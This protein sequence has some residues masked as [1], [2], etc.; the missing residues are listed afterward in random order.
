M[1]R[2]ARSVAVPP[3]RWLETPLPARA[4]LPGPPPP[5][6]AKTRTAGDRTGPPPP[7]PPSDQENARQP[8]TVNRAVKN[9]GCAFRSSSPPH[10]T[11]EN[12][13]GTPGGESQISCDCDTRTRH[14]GYRPPVR[15][16][17]RNDRRC[18]RILPGAVR[19]AATACK[20]CGGRDDG[21]LRSGRCGGGGPGPGRL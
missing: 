20:F 17:T 12:A 3:H 5:G 15:P 6:T 21:A 4:I 2:P 8:G 19:A 10:C 18:G 7:P 14:V 1:R 13:A 16:G 11:P 9:T